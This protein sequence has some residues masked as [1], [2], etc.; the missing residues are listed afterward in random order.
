MYVSYVCAV[1]LGGM[2]P[3]SYINIPPTCHT[4]VVTS[5][6]STD[7][8]KQQHIA[9]RTSLR[10]EVSSLIECLDELQDDYRCVTHMTTH[11]HIWHTHTCIYIYI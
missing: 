1:R 4:R 5:Q 2:I 8:S 7:E 3:R 9:Q 6:T 10:F 11:T